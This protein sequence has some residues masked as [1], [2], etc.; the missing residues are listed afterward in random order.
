MMNFRASLLLITAIPLCHYSAPGFGGDETVDWLR[1]QRLNQQNRQQLE[2]MQRQ[3]SP[4]PSPQPFPFDQTGERLHA[5][6]R[7]GLSRLQEQ[8]RRAQIIDAHRQRILSDE[9][10]ANVRQRIQLQQMRNS[11]TQRHLLNRYRM[12]NFLYR[13]AR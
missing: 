9:A 13:F 8:Q 5:Q 7:S 6:Q 4:A 1:L 10:G 12:Q 11:Q 2:L 3:F